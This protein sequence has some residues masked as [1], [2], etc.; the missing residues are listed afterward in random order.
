M[1]S[2]YAHHPSEIKAVIA[3][4]KT[5]CKKLT[6]VFEPHTF[7]RTAHLVDE[8][9]SAFFD[10]DTVII[11]PTY[12]ARETVSDGIDSE[13]LFYALK[14]NNKYYLEN[15]EDCVTLLKNLERDSGIILLLGAGSI[16]SMKN[17]LIKG[18]QTENP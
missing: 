18:K 14:H 2:D 15:Y 11:L 9:A 3:A 16:D 17:M 10:A 13:S 4:A 1:I 6:A 5:E 12:S 7:S 8:F